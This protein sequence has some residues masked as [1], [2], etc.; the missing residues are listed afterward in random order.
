MKLA[1]FLLIMA[2]VGFAQAAPN[3]IPIH[4]TDAQTS[5]VVAAYDKAVLLQV[6][7]AQVQ[8]NLQDLQKEAIQASK[9][10]DAIVSKTVEEAKLPAGTKFNVNYKTGE[11]TGIPPVDAKGPAKPDASK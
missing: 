1:A 8:K 11:V 6:E 4:L 3:T 10:Y 9:D 7:Y 2:G 5:A